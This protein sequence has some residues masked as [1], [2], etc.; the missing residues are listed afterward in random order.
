MISVFPYLGRTVVGRVG[1]PAAV[2]G[3][4]DPAAPVVEAAVA[5]MRVA[6]V[7]PAPP[8]AAPLDAPC[9]IG[10]AL[11]PVFGGVAGGGG[12]RGA[13]FLGPHP[14]APA[15]GKFGTSSALYAGARWLYK[16]ISSLRQSLTNVPSNLQG[17]SYLK[18][19]GYVI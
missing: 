18:E 12:G 11:T 3:V 14:L 16:S 7:N 1:P 4:G 2:V 5:G 19:I 15:A 8:Q 17:Y 6:L 13:L 10:A 9:I